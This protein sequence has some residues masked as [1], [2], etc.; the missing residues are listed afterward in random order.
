MRW[1][2]AE[3]NQV[4]ASIWRRVIIDYNLGGYGPYYD[5][6][7]DRNPKKEAK[8]LQHLRMSQEYTATNHMR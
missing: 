1:W 6:L 2:N 3:A 5:E 8:V 4:S 7:R